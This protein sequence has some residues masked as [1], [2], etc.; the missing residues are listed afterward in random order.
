MKWNFR[1]RVAEFRKGL[2]TV[3]CRHPLE[4][5]LLL[6]LTVML[7]VCLEID[8]DPNGPRM[9]VLGWGALL[10][11]VVNRL[12]GRSVWRRIY[13][14]AWAPLVPLFL[15]PGLPEWVESAQAV[16]T[17]AILTPL[18]LLA[19]RR[20]VANERFVADALVYLRS[21][22][23]A[24]LFAYV[25]YGL[26]EAILWSAAYIFG[27]S[28]A[29]WVAHLSADLFF[30]TQF[31]A[32]PTLFMMMLDRWDE[33]RFGSSRILEVL[34]NWIFT[35]AVAIYAAILYLYL[36]KILFT[37]TLPEGGVAYLVFGF[38]I[39]ALLV[40]ALR[41]P[42][43]KRTLDWFYDR[44]SLLA[45]PLV[46]LFWVGVA[47]RVGEY[48]LTVSRIYLLLCGGLMTFCILLFLSRRAGRYLWVVLAAIV[49]FAAVA[50]IPALEP[51]R[52]ALRS[53]TRRV[54]RIAERLGR[55]DAATG[56]LSLAP[57]SLADTTFRK[58][59]RELYEALAYVERDSAAFA[60]FGVEESNDLVE[61]LPTVMHD[62]VQ[63]GWEPAVGEVVEAN[64]SVEVYLPQNAGFEV[65]GSYSRCYVNLTVWN[66]ESYSFGNDTL[67]FYLGEERPVLEVTGAEVL[68]KQLGQSGFDLSTGLE[69]SREQALRL[70]NYRDDRCCIL[71]DHLSVERRDSVD[72]I[73]S[74]TVHSLWLR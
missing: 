5:L 58:E 53:Q 15:W 10:L 66:P 37:W 16:I 33:A 27:F 35:P 62:Y 18:A 32:V 60:R 41:L 72:V 71:F 1:E 46:A 20:A 68:K 30:V 8:E 51:E 9:L 57:A 52:A 63:W 12:A 29:R 24:M 2:A 40:K 6:A 34:L 54:E 64:P 28:H 67:R 69:P 17:F 50:Y 39:T 74:L 25:A 61:I 49:A 42:L 11:L 70:L 36:L 44:F 47:R 59:Y 14:V 19:C 45:L 48:G 43:E 3:V 31:L 22:V 65:D 26:F 38:T 7:I 23:L 21:A 13:W 56:R 4:L 73:T 55:L